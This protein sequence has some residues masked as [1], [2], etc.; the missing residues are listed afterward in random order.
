MRPRIV[1]LGVGNLL[2]SDDA[3]G[4]HAARALAGNPPSGAEVVDAGTDVLSTLPF[5][6]RA[7][8]ALIIDALQAGEA[9]GTVSQMKEADLADLSG[10]VTAHAVNILAARHLFAREAVWPEIAILGVEPEVLAY[11]MT[12]SPTVAEALPQVER[13]CREIVAAWQNE[14]AHA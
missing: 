11:G 8:R 4:V 2:M 9:P 6:E 12:L 10:T 14:T 13:R 1:I 7:D 3:V 5:L